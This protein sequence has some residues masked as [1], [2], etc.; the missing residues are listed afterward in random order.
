VCQ[1]IK[2]STNLSASFMLLSDNKEIGDIEFLHRY[3][4]SK[5]YCQ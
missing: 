4:T 2:P 3:L 5:K 1:F